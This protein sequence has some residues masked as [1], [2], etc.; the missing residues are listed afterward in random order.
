[1]LK[2][3]THYVSPECDFCDALWETVLC[4]SYNSGIDDYGYEDYDWN[5]KP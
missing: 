3:A 2:R 4:D 1:M 5:A